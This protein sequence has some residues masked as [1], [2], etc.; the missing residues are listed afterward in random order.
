MIRVVLWLLSERCSA[1]IPRRR[2][3][4]RALVVSRRVHLDVHRQAT[5]WLAAPHL[6]EERLLWLAA[7]HL[8]LLRVDRSVSKDS[9]APQRIDNPMQSPNCIFEFG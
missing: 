6:G 8:E 3:H 5:Q 2:C 9:R 7:L 4:L 1:A